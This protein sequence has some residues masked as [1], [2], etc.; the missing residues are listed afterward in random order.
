MVRVEGHLT[1]G[2]L[3]DTPVKKGSEEVP[4]K[5]R[6]KGREKGEGREEGRSDNLHVERSL[7]PHPRVIGPKLYGTN[8]YS[9][10]CFLW[11]TP[12]QS[13]IYWAV[14][15]STPDSLP[16]PSRHRIMDPTAHSQPPVDLPGRGA[17]S[18]ASIQPSVV[19]LAGEERPAFPPAET[20][21]NQWPQEFYKSAYNCRSCLLYYHC[22]IPTPFDR[23]IAAACL[24]SAS[25]LDKR[26]ERNRYYS[27]TFL[28]LLP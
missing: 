22:T 18:A 28:H 4:E 12:L 19:D 23:P 27:N 2:S 8:D 26:S 11:R 6:E 17:H 1:W 5:E 7:K 20:N 16:L 14:Y 3:R 13:L 9:K 21:V 24:S 15:T 10:T 25:I